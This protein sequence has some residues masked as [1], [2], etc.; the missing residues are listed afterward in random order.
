MAGLREGIGTAMAGIS[1]WRLR[2]RDVVMHNIEKRITDNRVGMRLL[3]SFML[4]SQFKILKTAEIARHG[5]RTAPNACRPVV[6][7]AGGSPANC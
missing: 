1:I 2:G 5:S 4:R 7:R 3:M 6:N